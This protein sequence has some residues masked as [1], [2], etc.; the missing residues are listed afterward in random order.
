VR[1]LTALC[2]Q[3]L[4]SGRRISEIVVLSDGSSD[5]TVEK[6]KEVLDTRVKVIQG[7]KRQGKNARIN[8]FLSL[9]SGDLVIFFDADVT[10]EGESVVND[11]ANAFLKKENVGMVSGNAQPIPAKTIFEEATNNFIYSLNFIKSRIHSGNNIMSVRGPLIAF[12]RP[13]AQ[14][15]KVPYLVPDDRYSYFACLEN[16][17]KFVYESKAKVFFK[18]PQTLHEQVAQCLR[19]KKD[20]ENLKNYVNQNVINTQ[21]YVP[22]HLKILAL[23]IQL[24]RNPLAYIVMKYIQIKVMLSTQKDQANTWTMLTSTKS[25]L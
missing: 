25:F 19:Y 12:S 6:T 10:L 23:F 16:K 2:A 5:S 17:F 7:T 3:K 4:D 24:T 1:L 20:K 9:F 21:Y 8:Q 13:F 11:I 22:L 14:I 15:L 18:S